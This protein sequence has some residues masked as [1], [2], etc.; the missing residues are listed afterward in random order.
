MYVHGGMGGERWRGREGENGENGE[1]GERGSEHDGYAHIFHRG[2]QRVVLQARGRNPARRS[3]AQAGGMA[4]GRKHGGAGARVVALAHA[5]RSAET[6][7][8]QRAWRQL[9]SSSRPSDTRR[10]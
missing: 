2:L 1:N 8:L 7:C 5:R 6:V 4:R 10:Q 3:D 9:A